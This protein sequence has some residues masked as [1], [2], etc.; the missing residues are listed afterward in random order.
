[1]SANPKQKIISAASAID[2]NYQ[3]EDPQHDPDF[4]S[5]ELHFVF[6]AGDQPATF[7]FTKV[8]FTKINPF[9]I[10]PIK[11]YGRWERDQNDLD[12]PSLKRH[13]NPK[14]KSEVWVEDSAGSIC[15]YLE[16]T[17]GTK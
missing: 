13:P 6:W 9:V 14:R 17:L 12:T 16:R 2:L 1:M 10:T 15:E 11:N 7:E 3:A 8:G 4:H 5:R